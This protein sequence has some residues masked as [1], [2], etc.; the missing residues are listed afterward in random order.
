MHSAGSWVGDGQA[1][2]VLS[3]ATGLTIDSAPACVNG[4]GANPTAARVVLRRGTVLPTGRS[5]TDTVS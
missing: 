5:K 4:P 3:P 2:L 1:I